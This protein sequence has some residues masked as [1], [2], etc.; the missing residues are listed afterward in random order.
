[1]AGGARA[2]DLRLR[3]DDEALHTPHRIAC[4]IRLPRKGGVCVPPPIFYVRSRECPPSPGGRGLGAGDKRVGEGKRRRRGGGHQATPTPRQS[5]DPFRK[6]GN[7]LPP[8]H[9]AASVGDW[10]GQLFSPFHYATTDNL[11]QNQLLSGD[12]ELIVLFLRPLLTCED[13]DGLR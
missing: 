7:F 11:E 12:I 8:P 2:L 1:M 3:G 6:D 5:P 10:A 9:A 13:G 4:A